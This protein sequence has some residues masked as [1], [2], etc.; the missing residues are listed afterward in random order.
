MINAIGYFKIDML[1]GNWSMFYEN[2]KL[3]GTASFMEGKI[4]GEAS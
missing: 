1:D 2:G 4:V 3:L